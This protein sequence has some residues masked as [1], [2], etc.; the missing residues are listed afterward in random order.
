MNSLTLS[1]KLELS[2]KIL[3][4][5]P[6]DFLEGITDAKPLYL[7][8]KEKIAVISFCHDFLFEMA[9]SNKKNDCYWYTPL[10]EMQPFMSSVY[11]AIE[12][13]EAL[14]IELKGSSGNFI[15]CDSDIFL[16]NFLKKSLKSFLKINFS[17]T[18]RYQYY[19]RHLKTIILRYSNLLFGLKTHFGYWL[20]I[21][22]ANKIPKE[23]DILFVSRFEHD[24]ESLNSQTCWHDTYMGELPNLLKNQKIA[25]IGRCG[26]NPHKIALALENFKDF[27]IWTIYHFIDLKDF[28]KILYKTLS[29]KLKINLVK[30]KFLAKFAYQESRNHCRAIIDC[31][32]VEHALVNFLTKVP[33]KKIVFIQENAAWENAVII[34]RNQ[35]SKS[36][37]VFGYFQ[38]PVLPSSFRYRMR[39]D[40]LELK[41]HADKILTL[42]SAMSEAMKKL[43]E[44]G[45]LLQDGYAFRS[46]ELKEISLTVN[47]RSLPQDKISILVLLG[48]NYD[49][50][51][52]LKWLQAASL[53]F[54][55]LKCQFV[56]KG[57][58][59]LPASIFL[60]RAQIPYGF[61]KLFNIV[62]HGS[63]FQ[64]LIPKVHCVFFKGTTAGFIG[65][66]AGIPTI[67]FCHNGLASDNVLFNAKDVVYTVKNHKEFKKCLEQIANSDT[68]NLNARKYALSYYDQSDDSKR[69]I[70]NLI[71]N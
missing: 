58:P 52:L 63:H 33:I 71:A 24:R 11:R 45:D 1:T 20:K 66:A 36:T 46:P 69:K 35:A 54:D 44:W 23:L 39:Q 25:L 57:H 40:I 70:L 68:E 10:S 48:G 67:H 22:R 15:C 30:D 9:N 51:L 62:E 38:C 12:K 6:E 64:D 27:P 43:G 7:S 29:F 19:L 42:G 2:E 49:N 53:K 14:K 34:A 17:F 5:L 4:L 55:G 56:V 18:N 21:K 3:L 32:I 37:Y 50:V 59:R 26:G 41:P 28:F 47:P 60:D 31:L 8:E 13:K 61:D 65:L 16:L